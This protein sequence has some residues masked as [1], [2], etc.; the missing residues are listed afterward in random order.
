[1]LA[2]YRWWLLLMGAGVWAG[3]ASKNE[4]A[5]L[6]ADRDR[7]T[8]NLA[9]TVEE[10]DRLKAELQQLRQ[11]WDA[12]RDGNET[13]RLIEQLRGDVSEGEKQ[14][15]QYRRE[16]DEAGARA[17]DLERRIADSDRS[18]RDMQSS[19]A[20]LKGEYD[21]LTQL[22]AYKARGAE[23]QAIGERRYL[24]ANIDRGEI[25]VLD[26]GSI[27]SIDRLSH[28][29]ASLWM[30]LDDVIVVPNSTG[31]APYKLVNTSQNESAEATLVGYR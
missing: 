8:A 26:D 17:A 2:S 13:V 24:K 29:D 21:G 22:L 28:L 5:K 19:Y 30:R 31:M 20:K 12:M 15:S 23:Y 7:S 16:R 1:M 3:C 4:V 10:R 27:W 25:I 14:V 18:N 9:A 6:R 11:S